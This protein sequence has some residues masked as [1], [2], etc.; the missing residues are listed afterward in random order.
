MNVLYF[1]VAARPFALPILF[2][3]LNI[4]FWLSA[5]LSL[6]L[7]LPLPVVHDSVNVRAKLVKKVVVL[8]IQTSLMHTVLIRL[9]ENL[10][11]YLNQQVYWLYFFH[12]IQMVN[13]HHFVLKSNHNNF[14]CALLATSFKKSST[15]VL[16]RQSNIANGSFVLPQMY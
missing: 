8:F 12:Y 5:S 10:Y 7:K 14:T 11:K 4:L 6:W 16:T 15:Y 13:L 2:P 9:F 3:K 1:R